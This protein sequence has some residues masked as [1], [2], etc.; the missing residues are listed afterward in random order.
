MNAGLTRQVRSRPICS[1]GRVYELEYWQWWRRRYERWQTVPDACRRDCKRARSPPIVECFDRG[2]TI[3]CHCSTSFGNSLHKMVVTCKV[4]HDT[5][6]ELDNVKHCALWNHHLP[7]RRPPCTL[8]R[9]QYVCLYVYQVEWLR[10]IISV[11]LTYG[12][13]IAA[14]Y[15]HIINRT[16]M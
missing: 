6:I 9:V 8:S 11:W 14:Y 3:I 4:V 7:R 10:C 12:A 2:M 1:S 13:S 15:Y 16:C 5:V